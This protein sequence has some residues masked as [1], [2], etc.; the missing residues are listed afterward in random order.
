MMCRARWL[1][2]FWLVVASLTLPGSAQS[3]EPVVPRA[4]M[5]E[6]GAL[7]EPMTGAS[8][9]IWSTANADVVSL[10]MSIPVVP[11]DADST[12]AL[13]QTLRAALWPRANGPVSV[14]AVMNG[15]TLG[16]RLRIANFPASTFWTLRTGTNIVEVL[17]F[18]PPDALASLT[19]DVPSSS[20]KTPPS[21]PK[22]EVEVT[23]ASR[24]CALMTGLSTRIASGEKPRLTQYI[25]RTS[26]GVEFTT[27]E[28]GDPALVDQATRVVDSQ[29]FF[30][31]G[32]ARKALTKIMASS[33]C[34]KLNNGG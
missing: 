1:V 13:A 25:Y 5:A 2:A 20:A 29:G 10:G 8:T 31:F 27:L 34:Q 15:V 11:N 7:L 4:L 21:A 22:V 19:V 32:T 24:R 33:G 28:A 6:V 23:L 3:Q 12:I 30:Q 26:N 14:Q 16:A 9:V 18:L 17:V